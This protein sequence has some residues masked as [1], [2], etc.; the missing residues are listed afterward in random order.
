MAQ[1][2]INVGAVQNDHTGDLNRSAFIKINDNFTKLYESIDAHEDVDTSTIPP[3]TGDS[4]VWNGQKWVP[5]DN[6]NNDGEYGISCF[7]VGSVIERDIVLYHIIPWTVVFPIDFIGSKASV[8]TAPTIDIYFDIFINETNVGQ[9]IFPQDSNTGNFSAPSEMVTY[10]G[11]EIKIIASG[12]TTI[13]LVDLTITLVGIDNGTSLAYRGIRTVQGLQ[14][15]QGPSSVSDITVEDNVGLTYDADTNILSSI[16]NTTIPDNVMSVP[17]GVVESM[18]ASEWKIKNLVEVFDTILFPTIDASITTNKSVTLTVF[19]SSTYDEIGRT[20]NRTLTAIFNQGRITNG[21]GSVGPTVVGAPTLYTFSGPNIV[22]DVSQENNEYTS[23]F[24]VIEGNNIW[25]VV[26]L[27]DANDIAYYD[28]KGNIGTNLDAYRVASSVSDQSPA[29][30]GIYPYF[31]G[32]SDTLLSVSQIKSI[33]ESGNSNKVLLPSSGTIS[34]IFNTVSHYLWF[35][36]D[37]SKTTKTKWYVT[38][39]NQGYIGSPTDLFGEVN[40]S[41]INSPSDYWNNKQFKIYRS[42]YATS[43]D[44]IIELRNN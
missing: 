44:T 42:N 2:N 10:I 24:D 20:V 13:D 26:T 40:L 8:L 1:K 38:A 19:E 31:W 33:I 27:H 12:N 25:N 17:I 15:I 4:L 11:D 30:I 34:I 32:V 43:L 37:A 22:P 35:A 9:L 41:T 36:H 39:L 5:K 18:P 14:G 7:S 16:Y 28:N 29:I 21:D 23:D 3:T 6:T